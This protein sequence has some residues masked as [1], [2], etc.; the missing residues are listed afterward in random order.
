MPS[1]S[2]YGLLAISHL[3]IKILQ[4]IDKNNINSIVKWSRQ[5]KYLK[6]RN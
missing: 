5:E 3:A 2:F 4:Q 1:S 6:L